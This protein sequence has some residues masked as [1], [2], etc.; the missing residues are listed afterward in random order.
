MRKSKGFTEL[1]SLN[2]ETSVYKRKQKSKNVDPR[3]MFTLSESDELP[4][5]PVGTSVTF[6]PLTSTVMIN[7]WQ[8]N[9][10]SAPQSR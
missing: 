10:A 5:R 3:G 9:H 2:A 6:A 4:K 7:A 1:A 8:R